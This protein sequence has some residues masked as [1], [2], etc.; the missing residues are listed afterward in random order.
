[1]KGKHAAINGAF[2]TVR[3]VKMSHLLHLKFSESTRVVYETS[4]ATNINIKNINININIV[5]AHVSANTRKFAQRVKE[6]FVR[7]K[8]H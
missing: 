7:F 4:I 5:K 1:M 2:A 8:K 3:E 6:L